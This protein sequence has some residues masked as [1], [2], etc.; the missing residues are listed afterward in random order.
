MVK[1]AAKK[2]NNQS[3]RILAKQ[4]GTGARE[5]KGEK[6]IMGRGK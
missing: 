5:S 4:R 3:G 2:E 6:T 1:T